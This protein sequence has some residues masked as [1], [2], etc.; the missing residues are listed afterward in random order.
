VQT[1]LPDD[2]VETPTSVDDVWGPCL[3]IQ[4]AYAADATTRHKGATGGVLTA[5]CD[6]LIA[7]GT[8]AAI[9]HVSAGGVRPSFGQAQI[10]ANRK[11]LLEGAGSRYGPAAPLG[12]LAEMLDRGERFA[13]VAKPCDISAARLL[14]RSDPRV[15][16]LITHFLTPVCGGIMSPA[17][18][19]TFLKGLGIA[20]QDLAAVSYRGNG[21]PGPTR[22]ELVSGEVIE[23]T[24]LDIW[25]EDSSTWHLPW[26]CKICPDGTGEA[27]DIAAADT[28]PGGSPSAEMLDDDPGTNAVVVRSK[29]GARLLQDA[30]DAGYLVLEGSANTNDLDLWQPHQVRKKIASGARFE[31]M[32]SVGQLPIETIGLRTEML[33]ARMDRETDRREVEGTRTRI[34]IG[35]HRD[36]YG[37]VS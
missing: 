17:G 1:G 37:A 29:A 34:A 11:A 26:R 30:V 12:A 2:L 20:P 25:G 31:G 32:R 7:S 22:F 16:E 36:D 5:L 15:A 27:A 9:L 28:W 6:Y 8:A 33:R 4:R 14:G 18:M 35:K 23:K 10:S 13:L 24:Y 21:C 19:D 3:R